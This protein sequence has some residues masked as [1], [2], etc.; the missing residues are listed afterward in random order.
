M[1]TIAQQ[2]GIKDFPFIIRDKDENLLYWEEANGF[3]EKWQYDSDGYEIYYENSDGKVI[4]K[5]QKPSY[6]GKIV[7]IDGKKYQLKE[8]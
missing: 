5:R 1:K 3:Y 8:I 2:L 6:E 7:E 4:D